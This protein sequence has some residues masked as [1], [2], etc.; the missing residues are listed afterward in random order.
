MI[1]LQNQL[2]KNNKVVSGFG[3]KGPD[4][5]IHPFKPGDWVYI[6]AFSG[7]SLE[8]KWNGPFQELL[9]TFTAVKIRE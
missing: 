4:Q 3:N 1:A 6:K 8:E 5:P 2:R 7:Q 9:T